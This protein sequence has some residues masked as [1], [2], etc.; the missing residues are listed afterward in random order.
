MRAHIVLHILPHNM[1]AFGAAKFQPITCKCEQAQCSP[2]TTISLVYFTCESN[3]NIIQTHLDL[4]N[5]YLSQ[6]EAT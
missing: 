6:F 1:L 5:A 2:K 3:K 4:K